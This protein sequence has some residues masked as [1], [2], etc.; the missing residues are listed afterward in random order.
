MQQ[1]RVRCGIGAVKAEMIRC[2]GHQGVQSVVGHNG[3]L[4]FT[5]TTTIVAFSLLSPFG[6]F[7]AVSRAT[8]GAMTMEQSDASQGEDGGPRHVNIRCLASWISRQASWNGGDANSSSMRHRH[9]CCRLDIF[10]LLPCLLA[11]T[12]TCSPLALPTVERAVRLRY[13]CRLQCFSR[14]GIQEVCHI[15]FVDEYLHMLTGHVLG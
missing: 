8:S 2:I 10:F 7:P 1:R 6:P 4:L 15:D 13:M 3:F 5:H 14:N 12:T 9:L 11:E